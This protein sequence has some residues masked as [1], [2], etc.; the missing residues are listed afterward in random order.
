M[1]IILP[2]LKEWEART[3]NEILIRSKKENHSIDTK[4]LNKVAQERLE[5]LMIEAKAVI[6]L[7]MS[8]TYRLYVRYADR[9]PKVA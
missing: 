1:Q 4:S 2:R 8:G 3:W 6:S 7:R 9:F 5:A